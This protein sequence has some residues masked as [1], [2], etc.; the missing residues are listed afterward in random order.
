MCSDER[1]GNSVITKISSALEVRS[2]FTADRKP[3]M[4]VIDE[5]D[6]AAAA[7]NENNLIKYLVKLATATVSGKGSK[8]AKAVNTAATKKNNENGDSDTEP[9]DYVS[10]V[11]TA[12]KSQSSSHGLLHPI[13]CI[14]NDLYVPALRPLRQVAHIL[15]VKPIGPIQLSLRLKSICDL[16]GLKINARTLVDLA[17]VMDSDVRSTLN[18]LQFLHKKTLTGNATNFNKEL[19]FGAFKDTVKPPMKIYDAIFHNQP[20]SNNSIKTSSSSSSVSNSRKTSA[21]MN[22]VWGSGLEVDKLMTGCFEIYPHIKFFDNTTMDRVNAALEIFS[23]SDLMSTGPNSSRFEGYLT[24]KLA[25]LKELFSTPVY[26]AIKYP[27]DDY[28]NFLQASEY[29][30]IFKDYLM[31]LPAKVRSEF[32][33]RESLLLERIPVILST[34]LSRFPQ[35]KSSNPQLMRP[36]DKQKLMKSVEILS[37]EGLALR[38][39]KLPES[40]TY[41]FVI[42]SPI[43]RLL[44]GDSDDL[45]MYDNETQQDSHTYS[46]C[47][48]VASEMENLRIRKQK[49]KQATF[50]DD[51]VKAAAA[52]ETFPQEVKKRTPPSIDIINQVKKRVAKDFFGRPLAIPTEQEQEIIDAKEVKMTIWYVQNDGVSN[53]VRRSIKISSFIN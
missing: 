13:I 24:H 8:K 20:I 7:G 18:A 42:D 11:K 14:C 28:E 35:I 27:K 1:M 6:G 2:S 4:I 46:L 36:E 22:L 39:V 30:A 40:A 53:A 51:S 32:N 45:V 49:S 37:S 10:T 25:G 31:N 50:V 44:T 19:T 17:E 52:P 12:K 38:Q 16:E 26:S 33:S 23:S 48:L 21:L 43:N 5:I 3:S 29:K 41:K 9:E 34:S 15:Q 47:R